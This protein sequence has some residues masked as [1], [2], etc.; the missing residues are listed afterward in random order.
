MKNIEYDL[1]AGPWLARRMSK[2]M[3]STCRLSPLNSS[4]MFFTRSGHPPGKK[5]GMFGNFFFFG[6][7]QAFD[8][9]FSLCCQDNQGKSSVKANG[10]AT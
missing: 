10:P 2:N 3:R 1:W 6:R 7:P 8:V 9:L 5:T 4:E